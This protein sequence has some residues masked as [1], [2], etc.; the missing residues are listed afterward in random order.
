MYDHWSNAAKTAHAKYK[1]FSAY[2]YCVDNKIDCEW[3]SGKT[4]LLD[5]DDIKIYNRI[6]DANKELNYNL[7]WYEHRRW[8]AYIRSI[9]FSR[10]DLEYD[11][12]N[13]KTQSANKILSLKLHIALVESEYNQTPEEDKLDVMVTAW[14]PDYKNYD[15]PQAYK[16]KNEN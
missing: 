13:H 6:I 14:D 15:K 2:N 3:N 9:G 1:I 5:A 16:E 10:M 8:T 11:A 12:V 4:F 7:A